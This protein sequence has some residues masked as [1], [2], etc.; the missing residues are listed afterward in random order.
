MRETT[1]VAVSNCSEVI[2]KRG[3]LLCEDCLRRDTLTTGGETVVTG[4]DADAHG[5]GNGVRRS[6]PQRAEGDLRRCRAVR[7]TASSKTRPRARMSGKRMRH[8]LCQH[9]NKSLMDPHVHGMPASPLHRLS[10][11]GNWQSTRD[12]SDWTDRAITRR[13]TTSAISD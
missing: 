11:Q 3:I 8:I 2:R 1:A 4:K 5:S 12:E 7:H 9:A 10:R 13:T 6:D